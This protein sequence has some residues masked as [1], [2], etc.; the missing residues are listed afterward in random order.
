MNEQSTSFARFIALRYVSAG[1]QSHLVS[2]MSALSIFG[3]ALGIAILIIVLSVMNGFDREMR[4]NILGIVPHLTLSSEE[5]LGLEAWQEIEELAVQTGDVV[6]IAP[7]IE[8]T[9]VIATPLGNK[10][11]LVNGIDAV[12]ESRVSAIHRFMRAGNL[13]DLEQSKWGIIMGEPLAE[14]LGV[15]LGGSV[16]LF[17]PK[18]S[19]NPITPLTISRKFEVVGLF[20]VGTEELD[21]EL[22]MVNIESARAL[23]RL[24]TPY[25]GLRLRT[26]DVLQADRLRSEIDN[27]LPTDVRTE[28]WTAR[29]GSIYDNIR[30]SRNIIGFMLWLLVGVAAFNLVV[31]LIM[32]V[33]DKRGDIAILRT[34]GASPSLIKRIFMWQGCLIG[35]IGIAIGVALGIIGSLQISNLAAWM[36]RQFGLQ[37]LNAEIYPIDF[38]PSQLQF[39]DVVTV[40]LGVLLLALCA[41]IYPA[42]RAAAVQPAEALRSD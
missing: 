40:V 11:V 22:V 36:E 26:A 19:M 42:N 29:F 37:L 2:F 4:E 5:N 16:D 32:I 13:N 6:A 14:R 33:R 12:N 41:T 38:L 1:K 21:N 28:S 27:I 8:R 24:R 17:S 20:R 34:L 35:L 39:A 23:F 9:G 25:T 18:I 7:V 3:L 10:G 31:S 30:F 15:G